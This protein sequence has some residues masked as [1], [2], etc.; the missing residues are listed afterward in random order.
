MPAAETF[1]APTAFFQPKLSLDGSKL[2]ALTRFDDRHYSLISIDIATKQIQT[3]A[4]SDLVSVLNYWWKGAN[5]LLLVKDNMGGTFFETIDPKTGFV[6]QLESPLGAYVSRVEL[7]DEMSATP[8]E[9]LF[10]AYNDN[11][12]SSQ[13]YRFNIRTGVSH[14]LMDDVSGQ[15]EWFTNRHGELVGRL[16]TEPTNGQGNNRYLMW[17][18]SG[19]TKWK[20]ISAGTT[21]FSEIIPFAIAADQQRLL[22]TDYRNRSRPSVCLY[23]PR[24]GETEELLPPQD[25][26]PISYVRWGRDQEVAGLAYGVDSRRIHFFHPEAEAAYRW[27][28]QALPGTH[29]SFVSFSG[30]NTLAVVF[31]YNDRNPGVFCLTNLQT[32]KITALGSSCPTIHPAKTASVRFFAYPADDGSNIT[33]FVTLPPSVEKPPLVVLTGDDLTSATTAGRFDFL[34]QYFASRG[35]AAVR[36]NHRGTHAF[37]RD[38]ARKGNFQVTKGMVKD[39]LDGVLHL[40]Q[41]GLVDDERVAVVGEEQGGWLAFQLAAQLTG[42][43]ALINFN[44]PFEP[45]WQSLVC[46][47]DS[48]DAILGSIGGLTGAKAYAKTVDLQNASKRLSIPSW[49]LYTP[50]KSSD[51]RDLK[52]K[53]ERRGLVCELLFSETATQ[54]NQ[55]KHVG[56]KMS[57]AHYEAVVGF[58]QRHLK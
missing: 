58:L 16:V 7:I 46:G 34:A 57:A 38:F 8:D 19:T 14:I 44:T 54:M 49:H 3:L 1:F 30:D 39:V 24:S 22:A 42:K 5:L 11:G 15:Q 55:R 27:L 52:T 21:D 2:C 13:I 18:A 37:G 26:E 6:T 32:R 17:R 28:E 4:R 56:W 48:E 33:G 12:S 45:Y 10:A 43:C 53:L 29:P 41:Q 50:E 31:A 40:R 25:T 51:A 47:A 35:F 20:R 36:I 9:M 23:D